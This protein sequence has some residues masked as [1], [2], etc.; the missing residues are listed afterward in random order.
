MDNLI[1]TILTLVVSLVVTTAWYYERK[2]RVA[3]NDKIKS[4][5]LG[6]R[7]VMD[8][9]TSGLVLVD[10]EG[11]ISYANSS[12][13]K[14]LG[15]PANCITEHIIDCTSFKWTGLENAVLKIL[16][17]GG[18][19]SRQE[20]DG[21]NDFAGRL[22][23]AAVSTLDNG[24]AV[25]VCSDITEVRKLEQAKRDSEQM[26]SVGELAASIAHEI[27]NPLG[28]IRGSAELLFETV[29]I[30]DD[31]KML[32]DLIIRESSRVN[33]II[34]DF[35]KYARVRKP[36]LKPC[37]IKPILKE[38]VLQLQVHARHNNGNVLVK[39]YVEP[40]LPDLL[41]DENQLRQLLLNLGINA[42]EAMNYVGEISLAVR[43]VGDDNCIIEVIDS[44]TGI[45][46]E[47][48][49]DM[50]NPFHT[51]KATGSGLGLPL[52][53]RIAESHH[54]SVEACNSIDGG[55]CFRVKL[56]TVMALELQP[57]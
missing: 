33:I 24:G 46:E 53:K 18:S 52:V 31:E 25:I 49:G 29:N 51:T 9:I 16:E 43:S 40:E 57:S 2:W 12:G 8:S 32:F 45:A 1:L 36:V 41:V 44:G 37:D 35:L 15:L 11:Q 13:Y 4:A 28:S 48:I 26:A 56:P 42:I 55:A 38:A 19:I 34:S 17:D 39:E 27:R 47:N 50:F 3:G 54:G 20:F 21:V 6:F 14:I 7:E 23:G 30:K 10:Q 22:L 5:E